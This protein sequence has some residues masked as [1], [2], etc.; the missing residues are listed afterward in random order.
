MKR[1]TSLLASLAIACLSLTFVGCD[2]DYEV[3]D[4][5]WGVWGRQHVRRKLL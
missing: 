2:E 5:L 3:A 4:T 1:F